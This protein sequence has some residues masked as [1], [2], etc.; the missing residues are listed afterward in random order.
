MTKIFTV[1]QNQSWTKTAKF[2]MIALDYILWVVKLAKSSRAAFRHNSESTIYIYFMNGATWIIQLNKHESEDSLN[3]LLYVCVFLCL[4][5]SVCVFSRKIGISM[6]QSLVYSIWRLHYHTNHKCPLVY[7]QK[8][9][10]NKALNSAG[11]VTHKYSW[12]RSVGCRL[13]FT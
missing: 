7:L 6:T 8:V 9:Y 12:W 2:K 13:I 1:S 10:E 11:I 3:G 5:V 4:S